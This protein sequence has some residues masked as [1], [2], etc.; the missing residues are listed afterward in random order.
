MSS[1]SNLQPIYSKDYYRMEKLV[2]DKRFKKRVQWLRDEYTK[3]GYPIPQK[4]FEDRK[5]YFKWVKA[6][7]L[8]YHDAHREE[9]ELAVLPIRKEKGL[10][11]LERW[12]K[13]LDKRNE[14]L[15]LM[16]DEFIK[17]IMQEFGLDTENEKF[18]SF[19]FSHIFFGE[20]HLAESHLKVS[21]ARDD[22]DAWGLTIT[23]LPHTKL[24]HIAQYW[25]EIERLQKFLMDYQ[26]KNKEWEKFERDLHVFNIY[27]EIKTATQGKRAKNFA[28]AIDILTQL[29]LREE[30]KRGFQ[31]LTLS[32][33]RK[34]VTRIEALDKTPHP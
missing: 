34:A 22:K 25:D 13:R 16:P 3:M 19:I 14:L 9:L 30:G 5:A 33:I 2:R 29:R 12:E 11:S 21:L 4:G 7:A 1:K 15:P 26:G 8:F 27:Q 6:F 23:V 32:Q 31:K 17:D 10:N 24:E 28:H 20:E 18:H